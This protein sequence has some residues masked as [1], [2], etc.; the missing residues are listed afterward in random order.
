MAELR[1]L[2]LFAFLFVSSSSFSQPVNSDLINGDQLD[3]KYRPEIGVTKSFKLVDRY[4]LYTHSKSLD[5]IYEYESIE[6]S[7][8]KITPVLLNKDGSFICNIFIGSISI[9]SEE[10]EEGVEVIESYSSNVKNDLFYS[11]DYLL[12]SIMAGKQFSVKISPR[13]KIRD[14]FSLEEVVE[15]Y[16]TLLNEKLNSSDN[17]DVKIAVTNNYIEPLLFSVFLELPQN[18]TEIN[19][20]WENAENDDLDYFSIESKYVYTPVRQF[21]QNNDLYVEIDGTASISY[22]KNPD[23]EFNI[24]VK[25]IKQNNT[26]NT[27]INLSTGFPHKRS[28]NLNLEYNMT[29]P[30]EEY[31]I[32]IY[33]KLESSSVL[34]GND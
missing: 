6:W 15:Y 11:D 1:F 33:Q 17:I 19:N 29:S 24:T 22:K 2:L 5:E 27:V 7:Y 31:E 21:E 18:E 26:G 14:V 23:A 10:N 8:F 32:E 30:G 20:S 9:Y 16:E 25:T 13:G 34:E 3:L 4:S 12:Y 28:G